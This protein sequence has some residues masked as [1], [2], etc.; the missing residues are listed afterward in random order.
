MGA[1]FS[2][3][4]PALFVLRGHAV[5]IDIGSKPGDHMEG[6]TQMFFHGFPQAVVPEPGVGDVDNG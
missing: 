1:V 3:S 6:M 5:E 4:S 2:G